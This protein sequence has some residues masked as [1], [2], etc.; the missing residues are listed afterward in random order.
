MEAVI[1]VGK[2]TFA[3]NDF[4]KVITKNK[5]IYF[6]KITCIYDT[7]G[8]PRPHFVILPK[9]LTDDIYIEFADVESINKYKKDAVTK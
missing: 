2:K 7:I 4:V 1:K 5:E 8:S 3:K 9:I 6:G